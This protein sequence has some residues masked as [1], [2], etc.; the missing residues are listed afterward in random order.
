[1]TWFAVVVLFCWPP[2]ANAIGQFLHGVASGDPLTDR[3]I[4]W[5]RVTADVEGPIDVDW[6]LAEDPALLR[7]AA[8]AGVV[9]LTGDTHNVLGDAVD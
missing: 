5:T 4:I 6:T 8:G 9:V 7:R 3:V 1:M 2:D